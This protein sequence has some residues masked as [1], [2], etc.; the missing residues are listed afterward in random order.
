[1]SWGVHGLEP[2]ATVVERA[3]AGA[4]HAWIRGLL[5]TPTE[6]NRALLA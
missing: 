1:M 5:A 6:P 4:F 2:N 3:A